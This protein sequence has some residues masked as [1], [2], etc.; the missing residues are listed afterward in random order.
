MAASTLWRYVVYRRYASAAIVL[1]LAVACRLAP[2]APVAISAPAP[3]G[4]A[5]TAPPVSANVPASLVAPAATP[6]AAS[7]A[8]PT[9]SP[10]APPSGYALQPPTPTAASGYPGPYNPPTLV[11][12]T[13][14][15]AVAPTVPIAPNAI[16]PLNAASLRPAAPVP[17]P[18]FQGAT[19]MLNTLSTFFDPIL[20]IAFSLDGGR[21][22]IAKA[23]GV[24]VYDLRTPQ[25]LRFIDTADAIPLRVFFTAMADRLVVSTHED[26]RV[27][28]RGATYFDLATGQR[29]GMIRW[30]TS[31]NGIDSTIARLSPDGRILLIQQNFGA[32]LYDAATLQ[33]LP[34]WPRAFEAATFAFSPDS[35]LLAA[36]FGAVTV[37]DLATSNVVF[38]ATQRGTA[39]NQMPALIFSPDGRVFATTDARRLV[40]WDVLRRQKLFDV[41]A[42]GPAGYWTGTVAIAPNDQML[43][44]ANEGHVSAW[45]LP[46]GTLAF[47][48]SGTGVLFSPDGATLLVTMA[49]HRIAIW[50]VASGRERLEVAGDAPQFAP[51]GRLLIKVGAAA[52]AFADA[53]S[54]Q[55]QTA[56][57]AQRPRFAPD[58][59][60]VDIGD[61][62]SVRILDV[63]GHL[64]Q[65]MGQSPQH[66][67]MTSVAFRRGGQLVMAYGNGTVRAQTTN[68]QL[69]NHPYA[70]AEQGGCVY[71]LAPMPD[72]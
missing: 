10:A 7:P 64:V 25:P 28:P 35:R 62:A 13:P 30:P 51:D 8:L 40:V 14:T 36:G 66:S 21:L 54:G 18:S 56:F 15:P 33:P 1:F 5:T 57:F 27:G 9:P 16:S 59:R 37:S 12:P 2:M 43:A 70:A 23:Y 53:Q 31:V 6:T 19:D 69:V 49:E 20:D 42:P 52:Y 22:A 48:A 41:P 3:A 24:F 39:A 34:Y 29:S 61:D 32:G 11:P 68:P 44:A 38:N 72:G 58:G 67:P 50:D 17:P 55:V 4:T 65:A 63:T 46:S 45:R 26:P 60:L 47:D 71:Q